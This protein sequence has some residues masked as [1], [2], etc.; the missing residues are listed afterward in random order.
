MK[1]KTAKLLLKKVKN[2]YIAISDEFDRSRSFVGKEFDLLNKYLTPHGFIAD[3]GCGN[4]R[5]IPHF[6]DFYRNCLKSEFSYFGIDN[7]DQFL[8]IAKNKFRSNNNLK[9]IKGDQL[10]L[11]LEDSSIDIIYNI[12]AF[13]HIPSEALRLDALREEK[14]VLKKNG[15]LIISVWNLYQNKYYKYLVIAFFRFLLSFGDFA[16]NDTFIPWGKK[17]RR[18]YHAFLPKELRSLLLKSDFKIIETIV[19]RDLTIIAQKN[20]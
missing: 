10:K 13:H 4:G 5:I 1:E 3:V 6:I 16:P 9:F 17:A 15:K 20:D 7:N 2:D 18:Y 14:R 12:R 8:S 19:G 11:P